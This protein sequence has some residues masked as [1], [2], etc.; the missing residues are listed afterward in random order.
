MVR[1]LAEVTVLSPDQTDRQVVA[2]GRKLNLRRDLRWVAK[3]TRK[4]I[5]FPR[6][7]TQVAKKKIKAEY[8]LFH[9]LTID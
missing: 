6:K 3:R 9:L 8:S 7:Y 1:D 2:S 5:K 4:R